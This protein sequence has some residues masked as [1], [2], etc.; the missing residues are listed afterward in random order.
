TDAQQ[1]QILDLDKK[2]TDAQGKI[3]DDIAR[4]SYNDPATITP[5][6]PVQTSEVVWFED[7]FPAGV[8]VDVAGAP[9]CLITKDQGPVFSGTT[10]L[11]RT[12]TDVAQDFF[13]GGVSYDIPPNGKIST[14]CYI[15]P[16]NPPKA[17]MVQYH[18]DGWNHRAVWGDEGAIPFGKVRTPEKVQMG[19]LPKAGEW[20][21]LEV[22]T[23]KLGLKP[24]M[25]VTGYAFTQFGGTV[26]WDRMSISS[27]VD[28]AKDPQWS[29]KVWTEKNQGKKVDALPNDLQT[30]MRGKKPAEW[31]IAET[32]RL[33]DWWFENEYQGAR[34]LV[35]GVR[36]EKLALESKKKTL[37]DVIPATLIMADMPKE[38]ESFI[39]LRGQ[40]DKPGEKVTRGTPAVFPPLPKREQSTRLDLADWLV[41]PQ[42]PLT[43]RVTVNRFWQQ[44][45]GTGLVKT[46]SD[47]GSQG[48]PPSHPELLDWLAVTFRES[49]WDVKALVKTLVCSATYRQNS[50]ATP[51]LLAKDP[52]NRL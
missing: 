31:T 37:E 8:K 19:G 46:S 21:K 27:R 38:R 5:P 11:K 50:K 47:F 28:P 33:Q 17:I 22:T 43:A 44:F 39:M 51:E 34:S 20:V 14:Y 2:I 3:R 32:R 48:E 25:K 23:E 42:H 40:Y 41:S 6:P 24:G 45:F 26:H 35:E 52:E 9:T 13:A 7:G 4:L 18:V 10:A 30:V 15:D 16:V 36:G 29:W 1:K 49:G 12:A